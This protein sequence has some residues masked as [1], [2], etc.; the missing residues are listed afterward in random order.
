MW[1]TILIYVHAATG[2]VA[3]LA[4]CVAITGRGLFRTY[5][6]SL[7]GM[8]T[9]LTLAIAVAWPGI[10]PAARVL[11]VA[12]AVLGGYMIWRAA[13]AWRLRVGDGSATVPRAYVQ[14][15]R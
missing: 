9:F 8:E 5:L 7:V 3:L 12:F 4:G 6:W 14:H 15:V 10:G 11:F 1:H 13:Q 2:A